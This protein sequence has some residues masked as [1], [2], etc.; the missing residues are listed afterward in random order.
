[1]ACAAYAASA[2]TFSG[3]PTVAPNAST[4]DFPLPVSRSAGGPARLT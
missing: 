2:V 1:M 4:N 3:P